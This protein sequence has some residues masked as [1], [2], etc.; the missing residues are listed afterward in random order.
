M[1]SINFLGKGFLNFKVLIICFSVIQHFSFA[2]SAEDLTSQQ[3]FEK[4]VKYYDADGIWDIY[5]GK[6]DMTSL[7]NGI[8][9]PQEISINNATD[10]YECIRNRE[11][12]VFVKGI[13]GGGSFFSIDAEE[14]SAEEVPEKYQKYPYSLSEHYVQ[15][16]KEHHTFHF[17]IPLALKR[18]GAKPFE[19][20]AKKY[21]FGRQC[22]AITFKEYPNH[23]EGGYYGI[24]ITLYVL[25]EEQFKI[26]AVHFDN[27]WGEAKEGLIVLFDGEINVEGIKVPASKLT[28]YAGS[29]KFLMVDA[30]QNSF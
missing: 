20:V 18:A 1:S 19:G 3:I 11:D 16:Y 24:P 2:Q 14:Y 12:G 25:P 30:F 7:R 26:H 21:L 22:N 5:S 23:F 9:T 29:L 8:L 17:S 15:T 27:G 28:F 13:K 10:V 4:V 6:M